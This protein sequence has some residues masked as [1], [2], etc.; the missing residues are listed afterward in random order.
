MLASLN[1]KDQFVLEREEH[2]PIAAVRWLEEVCRRH[3][4]ALL[5]LG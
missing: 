4:Q 5:P 3:W 2:Q 1:T